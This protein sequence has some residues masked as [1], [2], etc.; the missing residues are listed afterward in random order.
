MAL[1]EEFKAGDVVVVKGLPGPNMKVITTVFDTLRN[2][3]EYIR[4]SVFWFST[5]NE[6]HYDTFRNT[7]LALAKE[8]V[9]HPMLD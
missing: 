9:T 8:P 5:L 6:I 7:L 3:E 4:V 2:G 1:V